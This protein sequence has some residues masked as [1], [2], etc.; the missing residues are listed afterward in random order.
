MVKVVTIFD[1]KYASLAFAMIESA[2][3]NLNTDLIFDIYPLDNKMIGSLDLFC[4]AK[5]IKYELKDSFFNKTKIKDRKK[6]RDY[7]HYIF[8]LT[9]SILLNSAEDNDCDLIIYLDADTYFFEQIDLDIFYKNKSPVHLIPHEFDIYNKHLIKFGRINVGWL[10]FKPK[11]P[12]AINFL[13]WWEEKCVESTETSEESLEKGIFGDQLYLDLASEYFNVNE[14]SLSKINV[15]PC[16]YLTYHQLDNSFNTK[17]FHFHHLFR[18]AKFYYLP[19]IY[20]KRFTKKNE[21]KLYMRSFEKKEIT[22]D[23]FRFGEENA[24]A[25]VLRS[26]FLRRR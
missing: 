8:S 4:K 15:A 3:K 23:F 25:S 18:D 20:Y 7:S 6:T 9:P 26:E 16:N 21:K 2:C 19:S 17:M 12:E 13:L 14:I 24:P 22:K 11:D 5:N 1:S 10:S